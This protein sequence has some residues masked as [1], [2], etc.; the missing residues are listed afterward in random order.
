MLHATV[1]VRYIVLTV[2]PPICHTSSYMTCFSPSA[3]LGS[4]IGGSCYH[5]KGNVVSCTFCMHEFK[6]WM[7]YCEAQ[8]MMCSDEVVEAPGMKQLMQTNAEVAHK[9]M[10]AMVKSKR[11]KRS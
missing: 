9:L 8:V 10:V 6:T 2:K 4:H 11:R 5:H 3:A 7:R 1:V